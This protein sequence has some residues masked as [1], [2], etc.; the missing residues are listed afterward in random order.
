DRAAVLGHE[1]LAVVEATHTVENMVG[2]T[3]VV[4][5][6]DPTTGVAEVG[7]SDEGLLQE[8]FIAPARWRNQIL[9]TAP[10]LTPQLAVLAEPLAS[11]LTAISVIQRIHWPRRV[12]I[13]GRGTVGHLFRISL[14]RL[15][16]SIRDVVVIGTSEG[17]AIPRASFDT[18][19]LC[20]NRDR[21]DTAIRI[22]VRA[23]RSK[24]LLYL[25]GGISKKYADPLFPGMSLSAIRFRNSGGIGRDPVGI[26][27]TLSDERVLTISGSR[28]T[29]N[30]DMTNAMDEL[31]ANPSAYLGL[32]TIV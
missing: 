8:L 1:G 11:V 20:A 7:H 32:L 4:N 12:L 3:I 29:S 28:G 17:E 6:T 25:F 26:P 9:R 5:P 2:Q 30:P 13:V 16:N 27:F 31:V 18:A 21:I 15:C 23:L 24:G 22:G 14:P 10:G 19:V